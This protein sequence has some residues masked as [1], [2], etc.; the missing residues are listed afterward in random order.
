MKRVAK[1]RL[2]FVDVDDTLVL[3]DKSEHGTN[4]EIECYGH[5]TRLQAHYKN[6]MLL[7]KFVKLGYGVVVWS[8]T[9]AEWAEAVCNGLNLDHLVDLYLTKPMYYMDDLPCETWMGERIW[10]S[11]KDEK[12]DASK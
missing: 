5:V 7:K 3:W 11:P 9:G 2:L 1:E 6:I 4:V 12:K 10:R 8:R